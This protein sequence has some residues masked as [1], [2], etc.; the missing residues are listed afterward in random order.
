MSTRATYEFSTDRYR[1]VT[2]Y[3]HHD[4]YPEGAAAYFHEASQCENPRGGM[5]CRF[6]R[7]IEGAELTGGHEEH[8]DTEYRYTVRGDQLTAQRRVNFSDPWQVFFVG[9]WW[10]F[11]NAYAVAA[12]VSRLHLTPFGVLTVAQLRKRA[13]LQRR[14]LKDYAAR[15]PTFVGNI[16]AMK[17]EVERTATETRKAVA[18]EKRIAPVAAAG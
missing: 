3:I 15:F 6:I 10:D 13:T 12:G 14:T 2:L 5:A 11:V 1:A 8:G 9:N 7:A 4:G 16:D 18:A 17:R